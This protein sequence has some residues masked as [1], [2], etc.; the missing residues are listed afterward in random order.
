MFDTAWL[1]KKNQDTT[2]INHPT[3]ESSFEEE[4]KQHRKLWKK[5]WC[6]FCAWQITSPRH[7]KKQTVYL[8]IENRQISMRKKMNWWQSRAWIDSIQIQ[9][10]YYFREQMISLRYF[11][12][13]DHFTGTV[14]L[15]MTKDHLITVWP[16]S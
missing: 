12:F 5:C 3:L 4:K 15:P 10:F 6:K 8:M 14:L 2:R 13:W 16:V 9:T 1:Q 11:L 7:K